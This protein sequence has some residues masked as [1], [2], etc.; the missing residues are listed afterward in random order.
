LGGLPLGS[1]YPSTICRSYGA[2][3]ICWIYSLEVREQLWESPINFFAV[4]KP[5]QFNPVLT[6]FD[7]KPVIP[8]LDTKVVRISLDFSNA[9]Q[10]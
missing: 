8:E 3:W 7:A 6:V 2:S 1:I 4:W 10:I 5:N 9:F